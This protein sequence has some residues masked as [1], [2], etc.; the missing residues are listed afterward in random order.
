MLE[1][2]HND[3]FDRIPAEKREKILK[4]GIDEFAQLG[5]EKANINV[6]AK[7][8]GVSIGIMYKYF[9]TLSQ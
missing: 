2:H 8:A 5:F 3:A 4:T 6:I 9:N 1:K 7:K